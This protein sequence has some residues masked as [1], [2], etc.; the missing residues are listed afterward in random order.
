M[1]RMIELDADG[2]ITDRP[3]MAREFV[4]SKNTQSLLIDVLRRLF[5]RN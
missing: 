3:L 1:N 2:L 4:Y 5:V